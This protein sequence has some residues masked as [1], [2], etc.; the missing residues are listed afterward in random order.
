MIIS[1]VLRQKTDVGSKGCVFLPY[2]NGD[3]APNNDPNARAC[4]FGMSLDTGM[5]EICRSVLEG[6]SFFFERNPG[7]LP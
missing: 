7:G 2:F 6:V 5:S 1:R 3:S 4:F